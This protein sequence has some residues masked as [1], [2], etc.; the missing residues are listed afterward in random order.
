MK[1]FCLYTSSKEYRYTKYNEWT[2]FETVWSTA[3]QEL[4]KKNNNK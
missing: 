4:I 3:K 2:I 1:I